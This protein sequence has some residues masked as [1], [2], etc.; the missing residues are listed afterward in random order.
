MAFVTTSLPNN[1][2]T[3]HFAISYDDSLPSA[4]G[5]DIARD[6]LNYCESDLALMQ[7]WFT[8][9]NF[10][11]AFPVSVQIT[12]D[13]GGASW[14]DPPD[15]A[16]WFGFH[17]SIQ[18][19]PGPTPTT[20][21]VRFLIVAEV[22]EMLMASQRKQWFGD[23]HF[24]GADEGSMGES[25]SR[26]LA[27]Q[28]LSATGISKAIFPGF[29]VVPIWL[30]DPIRPDFIDVA[31]DDIQPDLVTGCGTCFLFF[32]KDQLGFSIQ[33]IIAAAAPTL[34]GVYTNLTGKT[35]AWQ[36]FSGLV[37][38]HYPL[39]GSSH[40]PPLDNIFPVADLAGFYAPALIS[41]VS[42]DTPNIARISL[43]H[44]VPAGVDIMLASDDAATIDVPQRVTLSDSGFVML[45]VPPQGAAFNSKV[46]NLTASYAGVNITAVVNVVRPG[47][48]PVAP[49]DIQPVT[50]NDP[51]AQ[52][53]VAGGSQDFVVRNPDVLLDRR[54]LTYNWT[55]IGAVA[56]NANTPTLSISPLP[57]RGIQVIVNV[58]LTNAVGIQAKG[59]LQFS[60]APLRT[61]L[62]E[63]LRQLNCRLRQLKAINL[64]IPPNLPIEEKSLLK[65]VEQLTRMEA[66][67]QQLQVTAERVAASTKAV[68]A[69]VQ[70]RAVMSRED[71]DPRNRTVDRII[72]KAMP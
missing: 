60:T 46:V 25:L 20:G 69:A 64:R 47:D 32:L 2:N 57:S 65:D 16:L 14:T 3:S 1:G 45:D 58:T 8:G 51:C 9:V 67:A 22:T 35:D 24:S 52:S 44:A 49:L 4:R 48:L 61:G 5:L 31:L 53:Y 23:T 39:G 55:V 13:S 63:E 43:D 59:T 27:S 68:R 26:F 70:A 29:S 33:Q 56:Q 38:L 18:I 15:I 34:A 40:F 50:N 42:N 30:N 41:W 66:Q 11:F 54:G 10:Q 12:G 7:S 21:L 62:S 37:A 17:P 28:F 6:L 72:T 19:M 71:A 36:A